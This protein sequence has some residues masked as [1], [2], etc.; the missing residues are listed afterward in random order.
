MLKEK[1]SSKVTPFIIVGMSNGQVGVQV[2]DE[3][4]NHKHAIIC[5]LADAIK[6]ISAGKEI[7]RG[8]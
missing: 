4:V 6:M 1:K 3:A 5:A 2:S 7:R 8:N